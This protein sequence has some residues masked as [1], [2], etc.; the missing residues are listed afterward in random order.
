ML[1]AMMRTGFVCYA[2]LVSACNAWTEEPDV[3]PGS[4]ERTVAT[5]ALAPTLIGR[6]YEGL[7]LRQRK[8]KA[9]LCSSAETT[10]SV[11]RD[12]KLQELHASGYGHHSLA[13]SQP[14]GFP[15]RAGRMSLSYRNEEA[16]GLSSWRSHS[17]RTIRKNPSSMRASHSGYTEKQTF[18]SDCSSALLHPTLSAEIG[19]YEWNESRT[20]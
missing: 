5:P 18:F 20:R 10:G 4:P 9:T 14:R 1:P 2:Q 11:R 8:R 17:A 6:S 12:R 16:A 13:D 7:G 3:P 15:D 19:T